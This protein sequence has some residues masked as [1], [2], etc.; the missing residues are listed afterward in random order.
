MVITILAGIVLTLAW[1]TGTA[2]SRQPPATGTVPQRHSVP[3]HDMGGNL[4]GRTVIV[5]V[6]ADWVHAP[7]E[8]ELL[9]IPFEGHQ[10]TILPDETATAP[11][12]VIAAEDQEDETVKKAVGSTIWTQ[13]LA[14]KGEM[15]APFLPVPARESGPWQFTDALGEPLAGATVEIRLAESWSPHSPRIRLG[16]TTLGPAGQLPSRMALGTIRALYFGVSHSDYGYAEIGEPFE[17]DRNV[18]VP[19]VRRGT[20]AAQRAIR[21]RVVNPNGMP[22]AGAI[23][24]CPHARTLGEG[25]INGLNGLYRGVTDANGAFAFYLPNRNVRDERGKLIPPKTQYA[26][27]IEA[28]RTT[29]LL[30]YAEP[31]ENGRDT[32]IVLECGDRLRRLRF[33]DQNG[34]IT[35]PKRLQN[36]TVRLQ[37][38][39]RSTL[40]LHYDDWKDGVALPPGTCEASMFFLP[41]ECRFEPVEVTHASPLELVFR[42]P[43]TVTYY[44]YVVHGLTGL[45][46]AGAFVLAMNSSS[47][48][49]LC[50]LTAGQWDALHRLVRDPPQDD[51]ALEPLRKMY[52]FVG[53]ARTDATGFYRMTLEPEKA[54]YGFLVF[55]QDYLA[56]RHRKHALQADAHHLAEVPTIKLFPAATVFVETAVAKEHPSIGPKWAI[57]DPSPPAWV[58]ELLALDDGLESSLEYKDW[59]EPNARQPV[60]VPAGVRVRL[61]LE[62]PYDEELCPLPIPQ[63]ICLGQGETAD[64]GRFTVEPALMVQ[65]KAID[66]TGQTLEGIPIR[67]VELR[68]KNSFWGTPHNTDEHGLARFYVVPHSTG[69][70]GILHHEEG[71]FPLQATVDYQ[72]GGPEDAG[73]EFVLPLSAEMLGHLLR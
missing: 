28:P 67:T 52:G 10:A 38:P 58:P 1:Q 72:V 36:I 29:R 59:L 66:S 17:P 39:G 49:R 4:E 40:T 46:L 64:L 71:S 6:Y 37:R 9:R 19:L 23:I 68:G 43:P 13:N 16:A 44:G 45:P 20:I 65:V 41:E 15:T 69:T 57:D 14:Q 31:M 30:P 61:R 63:T 12:I 48:G 34:P 2:S 26:V 73:R 42:L 18:I 27:R 25:L 33:E 70:F 11:M 24:T 21:G 54:F 35:D 53:L 32:L 5:R 51:A 60:H 7:G 50:D 22:V 3:V 55:E 47:G 56:V 8:F 62:L